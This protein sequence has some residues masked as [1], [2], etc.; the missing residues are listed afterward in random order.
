MRTSSP[1]STCPPSTLD[2][3]ATFLDR[4]DAAR[5]YGRERG[6]TV[7]G[8]RIYDAQGARL[9]RGWDALAVDLLNAGALFA[10][11]ARFGVTPALEQEAIAVRRGPGPRRRPAK[12]STPAPATEAPA[13]P[14]PAPPPGEPVKTPPKRPR[15]APSAA[16]ADPYSADAELPGMEPTTREQVAARRQVGVRRFLDAVRH[17]LSGRG[18]AAQHSLI[19]ARGAFRRAAYEAEVLAMAQHR[20]AAALDAAEQEAQ[21]AGECGG[22]GEPRPEIADLARTL[23]RERSGGGIS[24]GAQGDEVADHRVPVLPPVPRRPRASSMTGGA[25]VA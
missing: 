15:P 7:R 20:E 8:D 3:P 21:Q 12:G 23:L 17:V 1:S 9:A 18:A 14:P 25:H 4:A 2:K 19:A 6:Y 16:P 24:G 5:A 10:N 13:A 11:G 22:L